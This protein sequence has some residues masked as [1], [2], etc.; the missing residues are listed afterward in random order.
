MEIT[1]FP[2]QCSVRL[3]EKMASKLLSKCYPDERCQGIERLFRKPNMY[4]I[5][6]FRKLRTYAKIYALN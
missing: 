4:F 6:K 2:R 3:S 5:K 1:N